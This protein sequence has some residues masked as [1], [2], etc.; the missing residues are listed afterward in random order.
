MPTNR[1]NLDVTQYVRVTPDPL[2]PVSLWL[3]SHRDTVRLA[4]SD[5]QPAKGNTV[6]HELG[7]EHETL[8]IDV[9]ET[10]LW[11]LATSDRCAL[12]YSDERIP[13][14]I[15]DRGGIGT[16]VFIQDQ[17]TPLLDLLFLNKLGEFQLAVD[18]DPTS[19]F[20]T[21]ASGHGIVVDNTIELANAENFTQ[22]R[23]IGVV[24]DVIE[25]DDIIGDVY[26]T[27]NNFNRS[28]SDMRVDGS[29]T[30]VVFS[31]KPDPGQ[32]GDI[33]GIRFS[34]QSANSMDFSTFGSA[35][36]LRVGCLF[37][38]KRP[39]GAFINIFNF[40]S[41]GAF[42]NRAFEHYFQTKVGGGLHSFIAKAEFNGQ[43]NHGVVVR[44]DGD[45]G[46]ELQIVVQDDLSALNQALIIASAQ[47]SGIQG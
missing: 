9:V 18:T 33:N 10:P 41:N 32:A 30:P 40:K 37:R 44:L 4:F 43:D 15:S 46:E 2:I 42:A 27:G 28:T 19:R 23:V 35:P 13:I 45:L 6:F 47:G 34:I 38:V 8:N 12:T 39:N 22:S 25:I 24:G 7:G 26:T 21:A 20:F 3:Q 16:A 29:T 5:V 11:V 36:T 31:L 1:V 14:E 17:T